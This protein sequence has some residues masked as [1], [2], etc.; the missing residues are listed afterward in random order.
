MQFGINWNDGYEVTVLMVG[1]HGYL[2]HFPLRNF[3]EHQGDARIFKEVDCPKL[4]DAQIRMLIKN[5]DQKVKY[6][7]IS[8][9]MF[10]REKVTDQERS[11]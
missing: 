6:K 2:R 9:T 8:G 5:Y 10:V 4:T 3:G 11:Q 1:E 7:R